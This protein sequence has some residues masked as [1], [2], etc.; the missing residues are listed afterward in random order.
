M[1][2]T[3]ATGSACVSY[4]E[5]SFVSLSSDKSREK[6][7]ACAPV[8]PVVK[9]GATAACPELQTKTMWGREVL[10]PSLQVKLH[11]DPCARSPLVLH[12]PHPALQHVYVVSELLTLV[13][14]CGDAIQQRG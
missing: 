5:S 11:E 12:V 1:L 8:Q 3:N 10:N 13:T 14:W 7:A 4:D 9:P 6:T 2:G